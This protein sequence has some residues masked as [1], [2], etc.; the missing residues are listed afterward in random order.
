[1]LLET[2]RASVVSSMP[3][4]HSNIGRGR[5]RFQQRDGLGNVEGAH[6]AQR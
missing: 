1:M 3:T 4:T 6:Q 5:Q 2:I